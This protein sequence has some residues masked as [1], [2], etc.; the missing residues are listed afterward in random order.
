MTDGQRA[1]ECVMLCIQ[2]S[3]EEERCAWDGVAQG[4]IPHASHLQQGDSELAAFTQ[5]QQVKIS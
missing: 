4:I 3:V 2:N 5:H 1:K